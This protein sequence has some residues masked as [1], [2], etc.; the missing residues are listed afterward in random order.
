M[1]SS[2]SGHTE[3]LYSATASMPA[4]V[5]STRQSKQP[6]EPPNHHDRRIASQGHVQAMIAKYNGASATAPTTASGKPCIDRAAEAP[7]EKATE[8]T[9]G[10]NAMPPRVTRHVRFD[11]PDEKCEPEENAEEDWVLVNVDAGTKV[12]A[13][14]QSKQETCSYRTFLSLCML[15]VRPER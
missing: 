4:A 7:K 12:L 1:S 6:R 15:A 13:Q 14:A 5:P 2:T 10:N 9:T 8:G 3:E 11:L